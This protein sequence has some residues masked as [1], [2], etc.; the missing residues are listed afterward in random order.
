MVLFKSTL[1][2]QTAQRSQCLFFPKRCKTHHRIACPPRLAQISFLGNFTKQCAQKYVYRIWLIL[3]CFSFTYLT[4]FSQNHTAPGVSLINIRSNTR[5]SPNW[6]GDALPLRPWGLAHTKRWNAFSDIWQ[7]CTLWQKKS[8]L[9]FPV[10]GKYF[11]VLTRHRHYE[12]GW[13]L[14]KCLRQIGDIQIGLFCNHISVKECLHVYKNKV[15]QYT[16]RSRIIQSSGTWMKWA[17]W[18]SNW[19][20]GGEMI[21][22]RKQWF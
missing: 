15:I 8:N 21:I 14:S 10:W 18:R 11:S 9:P 1:Y 3:K 13:L 19:K 6:Y 17:P 7:T 5:I 22:C 20:G 12:G 2:R 16:K 4:G